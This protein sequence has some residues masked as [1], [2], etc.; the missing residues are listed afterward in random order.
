MGHGVGVGVGDAG[1]V[2]MAVTLDGPEVPAGVAE[3][4][5]DVG[6][7]TGWVA[8]GAGAAVLAFVGVTVGV[9]VGGR[10]A[11]IRVGGNVVV[12]TTLG[13]GVAVEAPTQGAVPASWKVPLP[14]REAGTKCQ[15]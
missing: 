7:A 10:V 14:C 2:E 15:S 6:E 12:G 13:V 9:L 1:G 4:A 11:G 3:L 5:G 8:A